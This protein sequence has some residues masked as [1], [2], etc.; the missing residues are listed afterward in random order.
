M[1]NAENISG[2]MYVAPAA[3][4]QQNPAPTTNASAPYGRVNIDT[5][6]QNN[7]A[8]TAY[9]QGAYNSAI[10]AVNKVDSSTKSALDNKQNKLVSPS[11]DSIETYVLDGPTGDDIIRTVLQDND[12][13]AIFQDAELAKML[14]SAEGVIAAI[15]ALHYLERVEIY[16]TWDTNNTTDVSVKSVYNF[17]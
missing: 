4:T 8:S 5:A 1:A 14:L 6:D 10:A 16:T 2:N 11:G 3:A 17:E 13:D 9:V 7:V 12:N 15:K